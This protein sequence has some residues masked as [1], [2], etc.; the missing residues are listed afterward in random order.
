MRNRKPLTALVIACNEEANIAR[1]VKSLA[2]ADEVLVVD[3]GSTDRTREV[4]ASLGA[5]VIERPWAGYG[6]Q[7]NYGNGQASHDWILSVD[8]DEEVTPGLREEAE[9]FLAEDGRVDGVQHWG[10]SIPR[11]TWYLGRW[12][13]HG[14]WY[15]NALVRLAHRHH[16]CWTEPAVHE[17]W[18]V[19]GPVRR[20]RS[21]LLHYTF[22]DVG[23]Q[24][25]TNVRFA[26]LGARVARERGEHGTLAKI[27]LRP[28]FKFLETWIWKRGFLDGLP[29]LVISLNAAHSI[30]MKYVELRFEAASDR[31]Q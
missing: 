24:V 28:L 21:D 2:W 4:A 9:A 18:Q 20:F 16:S 17:A 13:L 19:D 22:R 1:C 11:R 31:R 25:I 12:I 5:R 30:F 14:G 8:A 3:S 7:K 29:G 26:R 6:Q 10:A 15:P 27:F 23:E